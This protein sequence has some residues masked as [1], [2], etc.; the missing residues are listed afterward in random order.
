MCYLFTYRQFAEALYLA[1]LD[2]AFYIAMERSVVDGSAREAMLRYMDYSMVEAQT[3]GRLFIPDGHEHGVSIWS[4]PLPKEA[5]QE[6]NRQK[7][8]FLLS[9]MGEPSLATYSAI[10][11]FMAEKAAKLVDEKAWYLSIVGLAPKLQGKGLGAGLIDT[12]LHEADRMGAPSYLETFTPR[13]MAFYNRL[14]YETAAQIHE[15]VTDADYW[16]M[17]RQARG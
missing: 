9:H 12:I 8:R 1:L 11:D 17:V 15:P 16:L 6:K 5:A 13:N 10:V 7:E 2:D 3:Y 14:G 4:L